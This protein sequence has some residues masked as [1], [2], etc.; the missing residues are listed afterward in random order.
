M[1]KL[2]IAGS[3]FVKTKLEIAEND[4][5]TFVTHLNSVKLLCPEMID[6]ELS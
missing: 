5:L 6:F 2:Q 1:S 4:L 3:D